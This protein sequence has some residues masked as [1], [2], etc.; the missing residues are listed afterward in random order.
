LIHYNLLSCIELAVNQSYDHDCQLEFGSCWG[1]FM[2]I[3]VFDVKE[4]KLLI[5]NKA[6]QAHGRPPTRR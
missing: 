1:L 4:I 3:A 5:S 2:P 6:P